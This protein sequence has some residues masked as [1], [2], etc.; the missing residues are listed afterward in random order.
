MEHSKSDCIRDCASLHYL[1]SQG[2]GLWLSGAFWSLP[3]QLIITPI[4]WANEAATEAADR[5][6]VEMESQAHMEKSKRRMVGYPA[7]KMSNI[8]GSNSGRQSSCGDG[9]T[10]PHRRE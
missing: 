4:R 6:A 10:G 9:V 5:V 3:F 8:R 7:S 2:M 1:Q